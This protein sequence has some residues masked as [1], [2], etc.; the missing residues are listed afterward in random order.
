MF[1]DIHGGS[2]IYSMLHQSLVSTDISNDVHVYS[3]VMV[4]I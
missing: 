3:L 4:Y 2:W 1:S